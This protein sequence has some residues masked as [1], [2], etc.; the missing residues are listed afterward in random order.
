MPQNVGW[1]FMGQSVWM[2]RKSGAL[3]STE[4]EDGEAR[5]CARRENVDSGT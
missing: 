1:Q 3:L 2:R 5:R 4:R